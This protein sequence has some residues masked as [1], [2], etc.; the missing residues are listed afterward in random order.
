MQEKGRNIATKQD[1]QE[2]TRKTEEV[3]QEFRKDIEKYNSDLHFKY[4]YYYKQYTELYCYLYAIVVQS[5]Y[6][7]FR[8]W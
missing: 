2:I 1:I 8:L 4:D 5:E 7:C 3:Q 6:H